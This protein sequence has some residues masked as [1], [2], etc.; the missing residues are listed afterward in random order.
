MKDII[1]KWLLNK[2]YTQETVCELKTVKPDWQKDFCFRSDKEFYKFL[3]R[4][5]SYGLTVRTFDEDINKLLTGDNHYK[6]YE[7]GR[8]VERTNWQESI[9][10]CIFNY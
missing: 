10:N 5:Y 2:L 4:F 3:T 6:A 1:Y 8:K 9:K 7:E